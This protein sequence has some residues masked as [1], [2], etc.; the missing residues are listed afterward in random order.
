MTPRE[1]ITLLA[2]AGM[3]EVDGVA[4][5]PIDLDGRYSTTLGGRRIPGVVCTAA[6]GGGYDVTLYVCA[7]PVPLEPLGERIIEHVTLAVARDGL[8]GELASTRVVVLD[9][10]E[11]D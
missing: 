11:P 8:G 5:P 9:V 3:V 6:A 2:A 7:R 4:G 1:S 10:V